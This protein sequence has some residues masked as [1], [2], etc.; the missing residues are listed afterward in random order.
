MNVV[1]A[2]AAVRALLVLHDDAKSRGMTDLADT[3]GSA[4]DRIAIEQILLEERGV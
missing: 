3:Y 4:A 1:E 2:M